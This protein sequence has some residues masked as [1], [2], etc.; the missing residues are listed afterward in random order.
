MYHITY[1]VDKPDIEYMYKKAASLMSR[2]IKLG[3]V[4]NMYNH[5]TSIQT[6]IANELRSNYG[7]FNPNSSAQ[8]VGYLQGLNSMEVYE[9]CCIDDKWTSNKDAL[10][11]LA[12]MGYDFAKDILDYRK[13]KKYA[14]SIKSMMDSADSNGFIHPEVSLGKT[15]R[16]NYSKPAL[17][18]IPK[19]LLW[20]IIAPRVSG[21]ML[22]SA[23][24]KNQEPSILINLLGIEMLK[25]AL[26]SPSGLYETVF[27]KPF[28]TKTQATVY[29]THNETPRIVSVKEMSETECI[30]PVYYA[31]IKPPVKTTYIN[32][33]QITVIEICNVIT[34]IGEQPIMPKYVAVETVTGSTYNVPVVWD[35]IDDKDLK[36]Q[37]MVAVS[38]TLQGTEILCT[39]VERK[40]FKQSWN[41]MTYG[42]SSFGLKRICKHINGDLVYKYFNRIPEFKQYKNNCT[43]LAEQGTQN[44]NTFFGT[45][46]FANEYDKHRLHKVLMDLPIQGT[47]ADILSMLIKHF[48]DEVKLR[49]IDDKI[50]IYYTRHDELILEADHVW[51]ESVGEE[52]V[53]NTIKDI[54]EHQVNDWTPFKLEVK[55]VGKE[56]FAIEDEEDE[57]L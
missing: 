17:M 53:M 36:K 4:Q 54:L 43:K 55:A 32:G 26:N 21:N 15:N 13:A 18:N 52:F 29:V 6:E 24:I 34:R 27:T 1:G 51:V 8:V 40:E 41:A 39:G 45:R 33:E 9:A 38:G 7:I 35:K 16:I 2:G 37:T 30:P 19:S 42:V 12:L 47:G 50:S 20:H 5:F 3:D 23:D 48:D 10:G 14:E 56:D 25:E 44:I 57:S 46:L 31:P 11:N 28:A 22:Y 49:N